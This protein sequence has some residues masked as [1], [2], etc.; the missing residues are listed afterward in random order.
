VHNPLSGHSFMVFFRARGTH[1]SPFLVAVVTVC[2]CYI[3]YFF[4]FY[5]AS[6]EQDED[7]SLEIHDAGRHDRDA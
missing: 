3:F 5:H 4:A 2:R 1:T 6:F 7:G